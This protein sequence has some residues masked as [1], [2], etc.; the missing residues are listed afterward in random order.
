MIAPWYQ[1]S[2]HR[3][4][5]V[6][7]R[8]DE[9]REIFQSFA[10][11]ISPEPNWSSLWSLSD[12]LQGPYEINGHWERFPYVSIVAKVDNSIMRIGKT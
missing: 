5:L 12:R 9:A 10:G 2:T 11:R 7:I 3:E 4:R 6:T 8:R 1:T